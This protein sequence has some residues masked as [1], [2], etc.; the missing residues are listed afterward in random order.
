MGLG[1]NSNGSLRA[2][3][4]NGPSYDSNRVYLIVKIIDDFGGIKEYKIEQTLQVL[5]NTTLSASLMTEIVNLDPKSTLMQSMF[6]GNPQTIVQTVSA[7]SSIL[8]SLGESDSS[9]SFNFGPSSLG[10]SL[11]FNDLAELRARAQQRNS[12]VNDCIYL[13][14]KTL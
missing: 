3:I 13:H 6:S 5:L 7:M 14:S 2:P 1:F 8:N 9:Q 10:T 12:T 4:P 11:S